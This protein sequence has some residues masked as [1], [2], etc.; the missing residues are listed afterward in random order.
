MTIIQRYLTKEILKKIGLV[1][2]AVVFIYVVVDFFEKIEKFMKSGIPFSQIVAYLL[3]NMPFIISLILPVSI[4]L[5]VIIIFNFMNKNNETLALRA[6]GVSFFSLLRP[7]LFIG[8]AG[9]LILFFF[10]DIVVPITTTKANRIWLGEVKGKS[11]VRSKKTNIWV[12]GY[13]K[14]THITYYNPATRTAH[15]IAINFFDDNFHLIRK[16][17]SERGLFDTGKW[18]FYN[19]VEQQYNEVANTYDISFHEEMAEHLDFVPDDLKHVVKTPSEMSFKELMAYIHKVEREGYDAT[20][21]RVDLYAKPA[22]AF[23]CIIMSII[24]TGIALRQDRRQS[25]FINIAAGITIAF[26]YWIFFSFSLSLGYG[27]RLPP[28]ISA[29]TANILFLCLGFFM[30][31]NIEI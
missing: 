24:G 15:G 3:L 11:L 14:I 17:D 7:V 27:E 12:K 4:L 9:S 1:L 16:I 20:T 30:V 10:S 13:R 18:R 26:F 5:A 8:I 22:F 21:H 25:I 6:S 19:S 23:V 29:W 2:T 28:I 31:M